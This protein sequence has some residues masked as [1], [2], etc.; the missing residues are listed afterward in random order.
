MNKQLSKLAFGL[1]LVPC[2]GTA[3]L[4]AP[5]VEAVLKQIPADFPLGA[6]IVD[7][8]KFDKNVIRQERDRL[9]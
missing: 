9:R 2:L 3:L 4:A 5:D 8:D 7:F 1:L 6:V